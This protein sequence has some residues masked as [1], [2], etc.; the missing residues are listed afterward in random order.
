MKKNISYNLGLD[1]GSTSVGW[2][3]LN[4]DYELIKNKRKNLWG[5]RL[6]EEGKPASQRRVFRSQRRRYNRRKQ[7]LFLLRQLLGEMVMAEDETFFL[8]MEESKLHKE[9]KRDGSEFNL[10]IEKSFNDKE[11]YRKYPTIYHL[12]KELI[13]KEEKVD[14]RLVYLAIHHIVKYR[15]NFL[16]E[17][18]EFSIGDNSYIKD[19]VNHFATLIEEYTEVSSGWASKEGV[20]DF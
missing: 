4:A 20:E 11:Y 5:V 6:F 19:T 1:I 8:R 12:R 18:K 13:E 2:A 16:Y 15:G 14:P 10:F 3:V 17:G 7:R 9:E